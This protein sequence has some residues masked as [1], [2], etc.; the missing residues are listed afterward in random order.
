MFA[1]KQNDSGSIDVDDTPID[2]GY[3]SDLGSAES[4]SMS[5]S[6]RDYRFENSCRYHRFKEGLYQF[7]NDM[8]EQER[9]DMKHTVAVR[10]LIVDIGTG[11]GSW[12]ND[13]LFL[14][15]DAEAAWLYRPDS[16]NLVHLR[17]MSTAIK[18]WPAL[19]AQA[20]RC[21]NRTMHPDYTP[22]QI[23]EMHAAEKNEDRL[24]VAGF[25]NVHR[26]IKNVPVGPWPKDSN[27]AIK[28]G[29]STR[30]RGWKPE[31]VEVFLL[32]VRKDLMDTSVHSYVHFHFLCAQKPEN[33]S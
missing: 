14:V 28:M 18:D 29:P 8:P 11:T 21:D 16:L 30:G 33:L 24:R 23:I 10:L 26:E 31:E 25:I 13:V 7:P 9:E 20:Y 32:K 5:S 6:V 1:D 15:D 2:D 12:A 3:T 22:P 27:D 19:F 4:T 17:N